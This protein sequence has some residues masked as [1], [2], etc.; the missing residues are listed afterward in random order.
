MSRS[1]DTNLQTYDAPEVAAHY[2]ALDYLTPCELLL[3][4]TYIRPGSAILDLGVG[5]GRTTTFLR[6][7]ASR[8]VGADNATAMIRACRA[9]FP[10]LEFM[11]ADASD[12][13]AFPNASFD[14]VVFAFNGIDYVLPESSRRSCFEHVR[15]LLKAGG[16]FIFSSH[17][18][19]AVLVRP[20]WSQER[21]RRIARR[22]SG[23][24]R[25]LYTL[26]L[27]VLSSV[28]LLLA[29]TQSACMT[30]PRLLKRIPSATFWRG[31]GT[32]VDSVHGGLLT[33]YSTPARVVAELTALHL[34]PERILGD[35]F[36]Q[37]GHTYTTDWY[38]YVFRKP[39]EK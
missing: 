16:V 9:K 24:Q 2:A 7:R 14:A 25:I 26:F 23:D 36:P 17:N 1:A 12:L 31:Q 27:A 35:D 13:A 11:L 30:M 21:L 5:G 37:T 28:R 19:R 29:C 32:L 10:G 4:E 39:C 34:Q 22:G 6:C 18:P 33:H 20:S 15:R 3:F 8:Y 38:Y